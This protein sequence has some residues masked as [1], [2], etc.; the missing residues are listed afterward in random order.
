MLALVAAGATRDDAY[1]IVQRNAMSAW[2]E[3]RD[4]RALLE[5]DPE[6]TLS[7]VAMDDAIDLQRSLRHHDR[8]AAALDQL[9]PSTPDEG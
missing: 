6:V 8:V 1:R 5:D 7:K 3:R 4:F 2:E 9:E